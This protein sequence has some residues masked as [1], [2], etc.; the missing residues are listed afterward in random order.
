MSIAQAFL[1]EFEQEAAT[2]RRFLERLPA[3]K[4][5]WK[6]HEKSMAAGQLALHIATSPG[7][8]ARMAAADELAMPN[9]GAPPQ[10]A[11]VAEV[12]KA[13]DDAVATV[14]QTLPEFDDPRMHATLRVMN[15]GH[16][17]LAMPR[18]AF[19]RSI[20]LNHGYHHRGQ[21]GVYLR[22]MGAKVPSSYGPSGDEQPDFMKG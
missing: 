2:T 17:V 21:F 4:L 18:A 20:M 22:L 13:H 3:D 7:D 5:N 11:S 1:A 16:E 10:P 8:V 14:R 15:D 19:L 12:L 6:P 9:F